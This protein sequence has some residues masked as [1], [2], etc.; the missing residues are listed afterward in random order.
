M[1]VHPPPFLEDFG[2]FST[3]F[4]TFPRIYTTLAPSCSILEEGLQI[5]SSKRRKKCGK[6]ERWRG[7]VKGKIDEKSDRKS[8]FTSKQLQSDTDNKTERGKTTSSREAAK[9]RIR[10][11]KGVKEKRNARL[12][13]KRWLQEK[14]KQIKTIPEAKAGM[15]R[16]SIKQFGVSLEELRVGESSQAQCKQPESMVRGSHLVSDHDRGFSHPQILKTNPM[17]LHQQKRRR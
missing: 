12:Y 10:G 14:S 15:T 2:D 16:C 3:R 8:P 13:R 6:G 5:S 17:H 1:L 7:E 4:Y 9:Q 11:K